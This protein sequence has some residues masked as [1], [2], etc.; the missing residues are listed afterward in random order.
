MKLQRFFIDHAEP[1]SDAGVEH[2][3]PSDDLAHQLKNVF[4]FHP[5]DKVILLDGSGYE[6]VSQIVHLGKSESTFRILEKQKNKNVPK[7]E[8]W[9]YQ[10]LIKK[11]NFEWILEKGTELGVSHFVPVI[12][13]RSEKKDINM[14]RGRKITKEASE[15]SGRGTMPSLEE[16]AK[17][18]M[19]V[20]DAKK[21]RLA[22]V[23]FHTEAV[24]VTKN[25][26]VK[27]FVRETDSKRC[28]VFI[29]PEGGWTD[30][31]LEFFKKNDVSLLN[32]GTQILRAETAAISVAALF[33]LN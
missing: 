24:G 10:S 23:A 33:L 26:T 28:A 17:L 21:N 32:L 7:L 3:L 9:L 4:R 19:A 27:E 18:E 13:E 25:K 30:K 2:I 14:E 12:S 16:V 15:Q 1:W 22:L 5:G 11:D 6:Y 20:E 31:E 8:L 29:G